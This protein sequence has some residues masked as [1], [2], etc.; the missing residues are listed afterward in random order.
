M[1]FDADMNLAMVFSSFNIKSFLCQIYYPILS[2]CI[3]VA[4]LVNY[5]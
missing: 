2:T 5:A 4:F 3:L 1:H